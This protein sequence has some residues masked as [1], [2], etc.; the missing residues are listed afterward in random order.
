MRRTNPPHQSAVGRERY[1]EENRNA[2]SR[3]DRYASSEQF[4]YGRDSW[5]P[6]LFD[7]RMQALSHK[8]LGDAPARPLP[9]LPRR[10]LRRIE[11]TVLT[12]EDRV[13]IADMSSPASLSVP[14]NLVFKKTY[15]RH[16][17]VARNS[18]WDLPI[19]L[20]QLRIAE[21][22]LLSATFEQLT[23]L[24]DFADAMG[25]SSSTTPHLLIQLLPIKTHNRE[26][27]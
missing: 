25:D 18:E 22:Q 5:A 20:Q 10:N 21:L 1:E 26:V 14:D 2:K 15:L 8:H 11:S 9:R 3:R 6:F 19:A 27:L 4:R 12:E 13:F 23:R 17:F 7:Y 16:K 24:C